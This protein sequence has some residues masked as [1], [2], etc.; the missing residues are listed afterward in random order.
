VITSKARNRIKAALNDD[1]RKLAAD[2]KE[3]LARK[4][5]NTY[6]IGVEENIEFL[7]KYYNY[8]SRLEFLSAVALDQV[9][10]KLLKNLKIEGSLFVANAVPSPVTDVG[11]TPAEASPSNR[12]SLQQIGNDV[13]INNEPG[14]YYSYLLAPCCN[15]VQGDPIFAYVTVRDGTKIHRNNCPNAKSLR[16]NLSRIL[17][18]SWGNVARREFVTQLVI[19]GSDRGRGVIEELSKCISDLGINIRS[20]SIQGDNGYFEG[21]FSVLVRNAVELN[22]L[23]KELRKF[24]YVQ[25]VRREEGST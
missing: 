15:P 20:F 5:S 19:T 16:E 18:A 6:K 11:Q 21:H 23:I 2:G 1:K 12:E 17:E 8:P 4:L 22:F 9:D 14:T 10:F 25:N 13:I 3:I 7:A 24:E